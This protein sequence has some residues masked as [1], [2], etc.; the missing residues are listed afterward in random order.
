ML[1]VVVMLLRLNPRIG[2]VVDLD[3]KAQISG[4]RLYNL[5]NFQNR[6]LLRELIEHPALPPCSGIQTCDLDAAYRVADIQKSARLPALA[7]YGKGLPSHGL[8][9]ETV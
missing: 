1:C 8:N 7:V 6:E 4:R 3:R 5:S 2:Q 9:A